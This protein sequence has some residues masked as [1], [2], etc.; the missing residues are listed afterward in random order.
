MS[1]KVRLGLAAAL[2]AGWL[3]WL[4]YTALAKYRGPVVS[5]SQAAA[6]TLAVVADVPDGDGPRGVAVQEVLAGEKPDGR[7]TVTNLGSVSG[8]D[9][10]GTYLLL[11]ANAPGG[12][13]VVGSLRSP[14]Y[15]SAG[16]PT[17]YRW[18]P[19]V[20]AQTKARFR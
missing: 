8:Y 14:G 5:H 20:E 7:V 1:P 19:A 4:G 16:R 9:G 18:T 6:A 11:L 12:Y 13:A 17:V 3:G 10:P 2:F 15:E